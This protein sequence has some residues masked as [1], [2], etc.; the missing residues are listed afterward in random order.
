[1]AVAFDFGGKC[2]SLPAIKCYFLDIGNL[3]INILPKSTS[4][5]AH[6]S[7]MCC[8]FQ[9]FILKRYVKPHSVICNSKT[10]PK[11][12]LHRTCCLVIKISLGLG[13]RDQLNWMSLSL[14]SLRASSLA[15]ACATN[16]VAELRCLETEVMPTK[17]C[18]FVPYVLCGR[19]QMQN[20]AMAW[21]NAHKK[22][23][24]IE[25]LWV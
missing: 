2:S 9:F 14:L 25:D 16:W 24:S 3:I 4:V 13:Y 12:S 11:S 23:N 17:T 6:T 8:H 7:K 5:R 18:H 20:V 19:P 15:V 22:L 10:G 21:Q 1:M